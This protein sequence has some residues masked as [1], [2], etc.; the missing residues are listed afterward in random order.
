VS[1]EEGKAWAAA[2]GLPFIETSARNSINVIELFEGMFSIP[3]IPVN[4]ILNV[5]LLLPRH[6]LQSA[7]AWFSAMGCL[8]FHQATR[9]QAKD[10]FYHNLQYSGLLSQLFSASTQIN[11]LFFNGSI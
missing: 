6:Y 3:W 1:F 5:L 2:H 8:L 4:L 10:A 11:G 7:L 9:T